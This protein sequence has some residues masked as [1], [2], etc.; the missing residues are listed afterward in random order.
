ME[1][2]LVSHEILLQGV[3]LHKWSGYHLRQCRMNKREFTGQEKGADIL[4]RENTGSGNARKVGMGED[5]QK[6]P[7]KWDV[8]AGFG[9]LC[10]LYFPFYNKR[11]SLLLVQT[12][13]EAI[14]V[15]MSYSHII[16]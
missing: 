14:N 13:E 5:V 8:S 9:H 3:S 12:G 11:S 7:I 1:G 15:F 16:N 6:R 10:L 2:Y 4:S